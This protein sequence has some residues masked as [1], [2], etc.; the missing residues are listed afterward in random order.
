MARYPTRSVS[1][2]PMQKKV[3]SAGNSGPATSVPITILRPKAVRAASP[4]VSSAPP[5]LTMIPQPPV[6]DDSKLPSVWEGLNRFRTGTTSSNTLRLL[7]PLES[8]EYKD[9]MRKTTYDLGLKQDAKRI[10][11]LRAKSDEAFEDHILF[12]IYVDTFLTQL[13]MLGRDVQEKFGKIILQNRRFNLRTIHGIHISSGESDTSPGSDPE[14]PTP[15]R[16]NEAEPEREAWEKWCQETASAAKADQQKI[17]RK[18]NEQSL[19]SIVDYL[20]TLESLKFQFKLFTQHLAHDELLILRQNLAAYI[21]GILAKMV[22]TGQFAEDL[23]LT[24]PRTPSNPM[25]LNELRYF[26]ARKIRRELPE[27]PPRSESV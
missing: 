8:M 18:L 16:E 4:L 12:F 23:S 19:H 17:A 14:E 1:F 21:N 2:G 11:L 3:I 24:C 15:F 20:R 10:V 7:L 5:A 22:E 9:P 25:W 6:F 27:G 26:A 13:A